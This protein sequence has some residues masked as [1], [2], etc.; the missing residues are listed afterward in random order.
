MKQI[1]CIQREIPYW[2]L[3]HVCISGYEADDIIATLAIKAREKGIQTEIFSSDKDLLQIVNE[4][5]ELVSTDRKTG[6]LNNIGVTKVKEKWGV[7][8][9]Q[10]GDLLALMGDS[11]DN[12]PGVKGI[13][14]KTAATILNNYQNLDGVYAHLDEI[15]SESV[16]NKLE[17]G[18]ED[19]YLSRQLVSLYTDV[20][21]VQKIEAYKLQPLNLPKAMI[22][23]EYKELSSIIKI[24]F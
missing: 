15:K 23:L 21:G 11:A 22:T 6:A 8:P 2:G 10:M 18:R 14:Q 20:P 9:E 16:K 4:D 17:N 24:F 13:G 7:T 1:N 12:I 5:I 3:P 19:A